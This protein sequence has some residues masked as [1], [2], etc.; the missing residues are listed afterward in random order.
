[1]ILVTKVLK[2]TIDIFAI[3]GS[4]KL[5]TMAQT[6]IIWLS[7]P[8]SFQ[9]N[10]VAQREPFRSNL[11]T[12]YRFFCRVGLVP[13]KMMATLALLKSSKRSQ[14]VKPRSAKH[15]YSLSHSTK[16]LYSLSHS[17]LSHSAKHL[18][19]LSHSLLFHSTKH[20]YS[21]SH[22]LLFSS[23]LFSVPFPYRKFYHDRSRL[24]SKPSTGCYQTFHCGVVLVGGEPGICVCTRY[25]RE[26]LKG[27]SDGSNLWN[28]FTETLML[29]RIF[30]KALMSVSNKQND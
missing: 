20:L 19:S 2:Q 24:E 18:Y 7:E 3:I 29:S 22:S 5:Q 10:V 13:V 9:G 4:C 26:H 21:L 17:L 1:M 14:T 15:L 12:C 27:I 25:L 6:V 28:F 30:I 8:A 11:L 16:H 23:L